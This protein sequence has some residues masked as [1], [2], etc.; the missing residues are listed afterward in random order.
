MSDE[1]T[2]VEKFIEEFLI[3]LM[4]KRVMSTAIQASSTQGVQ[5]S[6]STARGSRPSR[7]ADEK[8]TK[9]KDDLVNVNLIPSALPYYIPPLADTVNH[10]SVLRDFDYTVITAYLQKGIHVVRPQ[11][12]RIPTLKISDYNLEDC[13]TYGM[14]VPHNYLTKMKGKR[15]NIIPQPWTMNIAQYTILNV[16]KIPHFGR[17]QEVNACVKIMFSC[18]HSS[19]L[20]LYGRITVD[21]ALIH[22]IT[23]LSK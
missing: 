1:L 2:V 19:Y 23:E 9:H 10:D 6:P 15:S 7:T 5:A 12:E 13:K 4:A 14:L 16:M 8:R 3:E 22:R 11:L 20:W 17:H 21:L 18:L